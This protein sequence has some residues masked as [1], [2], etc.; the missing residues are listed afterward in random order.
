MVSVIIPA[1]NSEKYISQAIESVLNQTYQNF[2]LIIVN[3]GSTDRTEEI[4]QNYLNGHLY[5]YQKN[6]GVAAARNTGISASKGEYI[7]FLDS[8]DI[9]LPKKLELQVHYLTM[10]LDTDLVYADYSTFNDRGILEENLTLARQLPRPCGY[11][12]HTLLFKCFFQTST[13]MIR[14]NVLDKVGM[15]DEQFFVGEDYDLWLRISAEHRI[16][17]LPEVVAKYR[18]H[19]P[20]ITAR[21]LPTYKPWEIKVIE[22][23]L[24]MFPQEKTKIFSRKLKKRLARPYFDIAYAAFHKKK[25]QVARYY[26]SKCLQTW[27]YNSKAIIYYFLCCAFPQVTSPMVYLLKGM[28]EK[29]RTFFVTSQ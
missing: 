10:H 11:I 2:E 18:Q 22:K 5:I 17:Y 24:K 3:D 7:A 13:V 14:R 29:T 12:F 9:W 21:D 27:P 20:S 16:G 15:F 8:D 19:S 6:K 28:L 25:Y 23:A 26:F 1:F 4:I